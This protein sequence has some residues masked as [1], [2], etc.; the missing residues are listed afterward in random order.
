MAGNAYDD[1]WVGGVAGELEQ[2]ATVPRVVGDRAAVNAEERNAARVEKAKGV[3][4]S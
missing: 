3:G 1:G 4:E 2:V